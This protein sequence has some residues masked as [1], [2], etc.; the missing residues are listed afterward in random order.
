MV[1]RDVLLQSMLPQNML[2]QKLDKVWPLII[3]RKV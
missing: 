2:P 1:L 3:E